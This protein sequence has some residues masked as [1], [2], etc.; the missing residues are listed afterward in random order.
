MWAHSK[1]AMLSIFPAYHPVE[2][3]ASILPLEVRR[4]AADKILKLLSENK[5]TDWQLAQLNTAAEFLINNHTPEHLE[6]FANFN[7]ALDQF[8]KTNFIEIFPEHLAWFGEIRT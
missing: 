5:F 4:E 8:Q 1:D 6:K 7:R 3:S 2:I